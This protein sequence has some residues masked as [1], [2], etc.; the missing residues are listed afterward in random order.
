MNLE[1][2][3]SAVHNFIKTF[4]KSFGEQGQQQI[5]N[6]RDRRSL[7]Q[8]FIKNRQDCKAEITA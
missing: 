3:A 1:I 4:G 7:R 5:L 8:H 2:S 6:S